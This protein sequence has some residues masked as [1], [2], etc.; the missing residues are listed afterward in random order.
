MLLIFLLFPLDLYQG[1]GLETIRSAFT[2]VPPESAPLI[3]LLL[4][5][6]ALAAGFK[7]GEFIPLVFIGTT[8]A[9]LIAHFTHQPLSFFAGLGFVGLFAAAA[10][11]PWTCTILAIEYFGWEMAPSAIMVTWLGTLVAGP[12]GIYPGQ[13]H[14]HQTV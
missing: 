3:K 14:A 4:T 5:A 13:R 8:T 10:K 7:G 6:L 2:E 12:A 1:L 11:T 9:S